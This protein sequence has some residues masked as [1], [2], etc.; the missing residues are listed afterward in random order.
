CRCH[1]GRH[2]R[3]IRR[4]K[5][6]SM[7]GGRNRRDR[8]GIPGSAAPAHLLTF[9]CIGTDLGCHD[10][11]RNELRSGTILRNLPGAA[12][13]AAGSGSCPEV[14]L[15]ASMTLAQARENF[16]AAMETLR[17]SKARSALTVLGIVIGVS[18]VISMAAIIQGLNKFVQDRVESLGSRTYFL[19]R[20]PPRTD[21]ARWP[22]RIRIRTSFEYAY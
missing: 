12:G 22:Q 6:D 7:F 9:P 3:A 8:A 21:P 20:F 1:A 4:G 14:G 16:I 11:H 10:G 18:S 17:S 13:V 19:S 2:T 15:M 5:P